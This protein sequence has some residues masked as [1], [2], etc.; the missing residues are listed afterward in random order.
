MRMKQDKKIKMVL[1][2]ISS[3]AFV[4]CNGTTTGGQNLTGAPL[5]AQL[6]KSLFATNGCLTGK[7]NFA[8]SDLWYVN[9]NMEITNTCDTAVDLAKQTISF[10]AQDQAGSGVRLDRLDAWWVS[11][12]Q[13]DYKITFVNGNAN[14]ETGT[15]SPGDSNSGTGSTLIKSGQTIKFE[16]GFN[17]KGVRFNNSLAQSSLSINGEAP[18]PAPT[19]APTPTPAP[20]PVPTP[21]PTPGLC[22]GIE[23]WNNTKVYN[24]AGI[25]VQYN[26]IEYVNNWWSQ[27]QDP[28]RKENSGPA[29]AYKVWTILGSCSSTPT[30]TPTPAPAPVGSL[31]V[32]V[33]TANAG[34]SGSS[35]GTVTINVVNSSGNTVQTF[36]VPAASLG[37]K[38][39]QPITG[40]TA[41]SY[42]VSGSVI[43]STT[44][45]YNPAATVSIAGNNT[46]SVT[47]KYN[48]QNPVVLTGKATINLGNYISAYTDS[49]NV[50]VINTK[51]GNEVVA[52]GQLKQGGAFTT[53]NLP[54]SDESHVYQV[55]LAT[56]VADPKAGDYYIESGE[57]V[58]KIS[59]DVTTPF[60][61]PLT[62]SLLATKAV[63][64]A[65]SG[66]SGN[67]AAGVAFGDG[68][69]KYSY[70]GYPNQ[71]NGN[72]SYWVE[73]G[74]N[75]GV[76]IAA[77]GTNYKVNPIIVT[78]VISADTTLNARFESNSFPVGALPIVNKTSFYLH[79]KN[80]SPNST[81]PK[82]VAP[83]Q[84]T[85][86]MAPGGSGS[87]SNACYYLVCTTKDFNNDRGCLEKATDGSLAEGG[88]LAWMNLNPDPKYTAASRCQIPGY[89]NGTNTFSCNIDANGN[90]SFDFRAK[91]QNYSAGSKKGQSV[92]FDKVIPAGYTTA[93]GLKYRGVNISGYEYDGT[94]GDA[95]Y[96][97][98]SRVEFKYFAEQGMNTV[99]L[100]IRW[101]YV[102]ADNT[103]GYDNMIT[104][105]KMVGDVHLNSMYVAGLKDTIT[106]L[107]SHGANVIVDMHSY[108]RDCPTG[109][110]GTV[111]RGQRN[112]PTDPPSSSQCKIVTASEASYVWGLLAN[113]L[114]PIAQQYNINGTTQLIFGLQNEP[115]SDA[116]NGAPLKTQDVFNIEVAAYKAIRATGLN[117]LIVFSGNYWDPLHGLV[118]F[119]PND[120]AADPVDVREGNSNGK[121][122]TKANL[123]A[124]GINMSGIAYE[125]HQYFDSDYSGRSE[126]CVNYASYD[127]FVKKL[128]LT[129][130]P[131]WM[132][133]NHM[134]VMVSEF[135]AAD[136]ATCKTDLGYMMQFM[137]KYA[138]GQAGQENGGFYGWQL[139]RSNRHNTQTGYGA[140]SYLDQANYNVY[141]GAGTKTTSEAGTGINQGAAN[142][143]MG[144]LYFYHLTHN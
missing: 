22:D 109:A 141:G 14:Q 44:I 95:M 52:S 125:A 96:Q 19:P 47:I 140:F 97:R 100:P 62:K 79:L 75:L 40:L 32:V 59:K 139:W 15:F 39:T 48:K 91:D 36:Q 126:T 10:T 77:A 70:V 12:N 90:F 83:G 86:A 11:E 74:L 30:P 138:L 64:L 9:G 127:D 57:P 137:E 35:C 16:G 88:Y 26:G 18:V 51:A 61:L 87:W 41:G 128:D 129:A 136:N 117:N 135:G 110:N 28:S 133:D 21:T 8:T 49:L 111:D 13:T 1:L 89:D 132:N 121:I 33:D 119:V 69:N 63:T 66:L 144:T 67:D 3:A 65:I 94:L 25:K 58:I 134:R 43:G 5:V 34:C 123:E 29:D 80:D 6:S 107:L 115:F 120:G 31:N 54:V 42:T 46:T 92:A 101:E 60:N 72:V 27:G 124:A 142:G 17:L 23:T 108:L 68:G 113:E 102:V 114:K 130:I 84:S 143:L 2:A 20:S 76:S 55:K 24:P 45:E 118:D 106:D 38:Y 7:V 112:E 50:Q 105:T 99:R 53:P 122:F 131:K 85:Y 103:A 37:G 82:I 4:G 81:C 56:G 98:P 116:A 93:P 73:S 78:Q 104:H 71:T